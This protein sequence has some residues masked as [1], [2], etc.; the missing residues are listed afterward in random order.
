VFITRNIGKPVLERMLEVLI[1]S[2]TH[3]ESVA[4]A[5]ILL[6]NAA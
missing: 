5:L 6:E 4:A 3:I 1:H 2:K